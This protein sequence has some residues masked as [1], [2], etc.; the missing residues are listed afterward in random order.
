MFQDDNKNPDVEIIDEQEV[1]DNLMDE[2]DIQ[3]QGQGK[4]NSHR[5]VYSKQTGCF[6]ANSVII[7]ILIYTIVILITSYFFD[8]FYITSFWMAF[9]A[10]MVMSLLNLI[11]KPVLVFMTLPLTIGTF[12]LFLIIINGMLL[13]IADWIMGPNFEIINFFTAMG[14]SIF[15]SI[16]RMLINRL[17]LR[18]KRYYVN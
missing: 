16:L 7:N 13:W 2:N 17:L 4:F 9:V 3:N 6:D 18:D 10:A 11:L 15:M 12:G 1:I 14:A 8:G 5:V